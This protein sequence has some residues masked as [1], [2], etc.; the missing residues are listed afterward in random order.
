MMWPVMLLGAGALVGGLLGIAGVWNLPHDFLDQA[1]SAPTRAALHAVEFT[2]AET[3][4]LALVVSLPL[5]LLGIGIA[6]LKWGHGA[7]NRQI[8]APFRGIVFTLERA[9]QVAWGWDALYDKVFA[10]PAQAIAQYI[11]RA[12]EAASVQ[13]VDEVS[14]GAR[15]ATSS[16]SRWQTGLVRVYAFGTVVAA[17][18]IVVAFVWL[19]L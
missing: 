16:V 2:P 8:S 9:G 10:R 11:Q 18:A 1:E 5:A 6:Y 15:D 17:A 7:W 14:L 3:W 13:L 19:E 4:L 12:D